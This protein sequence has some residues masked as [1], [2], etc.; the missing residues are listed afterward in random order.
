[1]QACQTRC[2][3]YNHHPLPQGCQPAK[4]TIA[5]EAVSGATVLYVDLNV[6]YLGSNPEVAEWVH[7]G[8]KSFES[9]GACLAWL[10]QRCVVDQPAS[11]RRDG[12]FKKAKKHPKTKNNP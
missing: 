4:G 2:I 10:W 6:R 3:R 7:Y 11:C 8:T 12:S 1:M 9:V 5:I